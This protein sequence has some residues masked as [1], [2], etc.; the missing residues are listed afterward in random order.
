VVEEVI[1]VKGRRDPVTLPVRITRHGP[2][3]N[4]VVE[5]LDAFV[6]LRWTALD[7][8]TILNSVLRL[9]QARNWEEFREALRLWTVPA[10]NFVYA[11]TDGNIGYQLPGRI[12]VRAKG[13]GLLPVPGW[14]GEYEWVGEIPFDELPSS[15]NPERGYIIT[16]N[17]RIIPDGYTHFI[18]AEWDPGFR[19]QRIETML[20]A[21]PK[22]SPEVVADMQLDT[23]SLPAQTLLRALGSVQITE[24]PEASLLAELRAWDGVLA[25]ESRAAAIYEAFRVALP[26]VLFEDLLGPDMFKRYL[27]RSDAWTLAILRLLNEPSSPW[28]GPAG[29]D[30]LVAKALV[31]AEETLTQRLGSDQSNWTWGRL[32]IMR[33]EHPIGR[34]PV[35]GRIFNAIAP[36]T[37]GDAF[38]VNN[39]GFSVKTFRQVVVA[40][41]RQILEVGNWDRSMAIHTTGQSG[42]PFHRHYKDFVMPWAT[43]Q[44][45]PLFFSSVKILETVESSLTLAPP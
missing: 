9:N 20:A 39:G 35:L 24:E 2:I 16:A 14:T 34:V 26:Q 33:F 17:N 36:P 5:G 15:F 6:A 10:Q 18:A 30:A 21:Q 19:A 11:D 44:Y 7:P 23:T 38:T 27:D 28:W 29:R 13:N 25:P 22:V 31:K 4:G 45:H 8:G 1:T 41:Y 37:G 40:S 32:H 42:L 3:L 43:G 12:P